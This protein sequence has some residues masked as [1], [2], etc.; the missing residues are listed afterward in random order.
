LSRFE[1]PL[2]KLNRT[3]NTIPSDTDKCHREAL[4]S[5]SRKSLYWCLW[6]FSQR[7]HHV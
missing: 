2:E 1:N 7:P 3:E 6:F 5:P 4:E